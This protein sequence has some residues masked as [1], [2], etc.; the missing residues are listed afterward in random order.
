MTQYLHAR[1]ATPVSISPTQDDVVTLHRRLEAALSANRQMVMELQELRT[2]NHRLREENAGMV[3]QLELQLEL[4]DLAERGMQ[5]PDITS[6]DFRLSW[7]FVTTYPNVL[8]GERTAFNLSHV[9]QRAGKASED[10]AGKWIAA[11]DAAGY[12]HYEP[13]GYDKDTKDPDQRRLGHFTANLDIFPYWEQWKLKE[14]DKRKK[15]NTKEREKRSAMQEAFRVLHCEKCGSEQVTYDVE[16]VCSSCGHRHPVARGVDLNSG[17][18]GTTVDPFVDD[19][20]NEPLPS[21]TSLPR[22]EKWA[23]N[24]RKHDLHRDKWKIGITGLTCPECERRY[25]L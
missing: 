25:G 1:Q 16:P 14:G 9:R 22:G 10:A 23:S 15:K 20:P 2:E 17:E 6:L 19:L 5:N 4:L 8:T 24:C 21:F 11:L 12:G 3:Q 7:S 18:Q 13:G